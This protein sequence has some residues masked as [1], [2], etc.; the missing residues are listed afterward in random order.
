MCK[1]LFFVIIH[2]FKGDSELMFVTR[3]RSLIWAR[4]VRTPTWTR[5]V[6][7]RLKHWNTHLFFKCLFVFLCWWT[8]ALNKNSR[9][10]TPLG[11]F[12]FSGLYFSLFGHKVSLF[13]TL[14]LELCLTHLVIEWIVMF[15][16]QL[17]FLNN[18][19]TYT[20][21]VFE[22]FGNRRNSFHPVGG[23]FENRL[24]STGLHSVKILRN[25]LSQSSP[26]HHSSPHPLWPLC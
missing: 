15:E 9:E 3:T 18:V 16:K 14:I 13:I 7:T 2:F 25:L 4:Q 20:W 24:R 8:N 23:T 1:F 10:W 19:I 11:S 12:V 6:G 26:K 17:G 22:I 5:K 21:Y